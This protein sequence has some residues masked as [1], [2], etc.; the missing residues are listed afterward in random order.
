MAKDQ[1]CVEVTKETPGKKDLEENITNDEEKVEISHDNEEKQSESRFETRQRVFARDGE[2][3]LLYEAIVRRRMYGAQSHVQMQIHTAVSAVKEGGDLNLDEVTPEAPEKCW[4]YFVHFQGWNV[5]WDRW[6]PEASLFEASEGTKKLASQLQLE[7]SAA[8]KEVKKGSNK[9]NSTTLMVAL[10][11]RMK[12]LE[13]DRRA[14]ERREEL[15]KK[16]IVI[17]KHEEEEEKTKHEV[18]PVDRKK[19]WDRASIDRARQLHERDLEVRRKQHHAEK[20]VVPF[21]LKKVM[22]E[23]W[24]VISQ[25]NMNPIL[26]ASVTVRQM[27]Q[28]YL[29]SKLDV[30]SPK[31][32]DVEQADSS[33][34]EETEVL[35]ARKEEW[36]DMVDGIA[37]FFDEALPYRLL[38]QQET[39]QHALIELDPDLAILRKSDLYGCEHLL[40]L[41]VH[42]PALLSEAYS[43]VESRPILSKIGDLTR[44]LQKHQSTLFTQSYRKPNEEEL[45]EKDRGARKLEQK[46]KR[47]L[48]SATSDL[49]ARK[50]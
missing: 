13:N 50:K 46:K 32:T 34:Q 18:N 29:A 27:L 12:Q 3:R 15:A 5:K 35:D 2:T 7:L 26:P 49:N 28:K 48:H 1:T 30:L 25:C 41:F 44:F 21:S 24:E 33:T 6:V 36:K 23:E 31:G 20:L 43:D 19:Q 40:R 11:K 4:Y 37:L 22:V 39:I 17:E 42:L 47:Q 14:E 16:G 9:L 38:Y 45:R 8:K 10:E